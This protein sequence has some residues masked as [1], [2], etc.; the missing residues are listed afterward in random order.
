MLQVDAVRPGLLGPREAFAE[1]YCGRHLSPVVRGGTFR[2]RWCNTGLTHAA[3]LHALLKQVPPVVAAVMHGVLP[4]RPCLKSVASRSWGICRGVCR[5]AKTVWAILSS[6][7]FLGPCC[8]G[9]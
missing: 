5:G 4:S 7:S 3:E 1:R 8:E 2:L 6:D 9:S